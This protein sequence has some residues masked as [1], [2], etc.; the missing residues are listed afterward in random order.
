MPLNFSKKIDEV[1]NISFDEFNRK[2]FIPQKPV[3][4]KGLLKDS[5][6]YTKW[7]PEYFKKEIGYV[8]VGV[9]ETGEKLL[10]RPYNV[11]PETMS[12]SEYLDIITSGKSNKR[13]FLFDIFK[14]KRSFKKRHRHTTS[15]K[16][17]TALYPLWLF[18]VAQVL[19]PEFIEMQTIQMFFSVS[20][21]ARKESFCLPLSTTNCFI[22]IPFQYTVELMLKIQITKNTLH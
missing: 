6:A 21:T 13:L 9:F 14:Q 18:L 17:H 12:L 20:S 1:E 3:K 11:A 7:T 15:S 10:D 19:L 8:K 4:I 16:I 22:N 2:Y 5:P